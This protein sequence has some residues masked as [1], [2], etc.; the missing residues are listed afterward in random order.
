MSYLHGLKID[1]T[2]FRLLFGKHEDELKKITDY[3]EFYKIF[4]SYDVKEFLPEETETIKAVVSSFGNF[5]DNSPIDWYVNQV[6]IKHT[7]YLINILRTIQKVKEHPFHSFRIG[8]KV[9]PNFDPVNDFHRSQYI[10]D[11]IYTNIKSKVMERVKT[12]EE[13]CEDFSSIPPR[14][15]SGIFLACRNEYFYQGLG[16]SMENYI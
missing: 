16:K 2:D 12:L 5:I 15:I 11:T 7:C 8:Y 3:Q 9:N 1:N 14:Y 4:E 13:K 6:E 10:E